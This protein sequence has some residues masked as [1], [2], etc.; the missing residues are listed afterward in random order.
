MSEVTT[1][2][3]TI[4][5]VAFREWLGHREADFQPALDPV[6]T[7]KALVFLA[8]L[9][10]ST[11]NSYD[12]LGRIFEER[13][14]VNGTI[15]MAS[16]RVAMSELS[17]VLNRA[18]HRLQVQASKVGLQS[19]FQL[20]SRVKISGNH[21]SQNLV[22]INEPSNENAGEISRAIFERQSLPFHALYYLPRSACWWVTF[23]SEEAELRKNYEADTWDVL[24]LGELV[25]SSSSSVVGLVGLAIGEGLGEIELLRRILTDGYT[26]HYLAV[27]LSPVL[28][29]AHAETIREA[30]SQE[31]KDGRLVFAGILVN[32]FLDLESALTQAR[33]A[34]KA[35]GTFL[36]DEEFIP[37]DCPLLATFLGNCLGNDE[38]I[39]EDS[40]FNSITKS[41]PQNRPLAFL[42]GVSVMRSESE[43]EVYTRNWDDFLLQTPHHLLQNLGILRSRRPPTGD[44]NGAYR[45]P[46]EFILPDDKP[47]QFKD[48]RARCRE[49][50]CPEVD[51]S[52]YS[53]SHGVKGKIYRFNYILSY[54]L[55]MVKEK[56]Q[57]RAGS[58][59]VLY[60]IIKYDM[61]SLVRGLE[62][63]QF[64]V[65]Y[66][67][68]YHKSIDT[69]NGRREYAV[70]V[71]YLD[72]QENL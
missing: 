4:N 34:F 16:L 47:G 59:I 42:V 55:E 21:E 32:V 51:V 24:Q 70:F 27:D 14:V 38:N 28:L 58:E 33:A 3:W 57:L 6:P 50:R 23:S 25:A 29:T 11:P 36:R 71:A 19:K 72:R 13:G 35:R 43:R 63:R 37:P 56:R 20:A 8:L 26:V 41:F 67:P 1:S 10:S 22:I 39:K 9:D 66:N 2:K 46:E 54:P 62:K 30:F 52:D 15:P 44:D 68:N 49:D 7:L 17:N 60:S 12:E 53:A 61:P 48:E 45:E 69:E 40:V 18:A 31:L 64:H 5:E 65:N